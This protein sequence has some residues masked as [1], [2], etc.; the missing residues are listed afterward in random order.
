MAWPAGKPC[1]RPVCERLR[2]LHALLALRDKP[3]H[4]ARLVSDTPSI[5]FAGGGSGGHLSPGLAIDERLRELCPGATSMFLCS[6]RA[7][8]ATMLGEA[9]VRFVPLPATPPSIR[10]ADALRFVRNFRASKRL[11]SEVMQ[12]E[13]VTRVVALGGF[14]AA[15]IVQAAKSLNIPV[16]LVNLDAPPGKANRWMARYCDD[17]ISAIDLPM[18]PRFASKVVGLPIRRRAV[19][20]GPAHDCRLR[21]RLPPDLPILLIT[22]ASQGATCLNGL[23]IELARTTP[24]LFTDWQVFHLAGHGADE[25]LRHAYQQA[26]ISATV[27]PFLHDMGLAWGAADL[28]ISRAG[29]NSV[30]EIALNAVPALFLPYPYHK[31][32]HQRHNAQPLVDLP[33]GGGAVMEVDRIDRAENAQ[34]LAPIIQSLMRDDQRRARMR[35]ALRARAWPDTAMTIAKMLV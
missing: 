11:A 23:M 21:L 2:N 17:V 15:P 24:D 18:L 29:A 26:G 33:G 34:H 20:P 3:W 16:L 13:R 28:A 12:R 25:P 27:V 6:N 9:G 22:G 30:A 4:P 14:V 7:I 1:E 31:D 32:M 19:A 35:D 8:D 5:V 10:P